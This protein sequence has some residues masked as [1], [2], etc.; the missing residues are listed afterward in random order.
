MPNIVTE[1]TRMSPVRSFVRH[2]RKRWTAICCGQH[3]TLQY[4]AQR[5]RVSRVTVTTI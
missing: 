5:G 2:L 1:M 3:W 4:F